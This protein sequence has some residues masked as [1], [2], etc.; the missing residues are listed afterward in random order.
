LADLSGGEPKGRFG[1]VFEEGGRHPQSR[2]Q[3]QLNN[4]HKR[5]AKHRKHNIAEPSPLLRC[6]RPS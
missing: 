4:G 1:C 6:R 3:L 2:E 5:E